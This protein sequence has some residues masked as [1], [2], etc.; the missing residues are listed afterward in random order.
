MYENEFKRIVE[1]SRK[2]SLTFFVGAGVSALS[3]A[4]SWSNLINDICP[5]IGYTPKEPYS[6]DEY[7]RIPQIFYYSIGQNNDMYYDFIQKHLSPFPL[8]PNAVHKELMSFNPSSF[9]TTNFDELLE[10]AAIQYCQSFSI[11]RFPRHRQVFLLFSKP[12]LRNRPR[13]FLFPM[14]LQTAVE[15]PC[16]FYL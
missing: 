9:I 12:A 14:T 7:L 13:L 6:S 11:G 5:Q 3:K 10:D 1:A 15:K 16:Q 8:A 2:N 4:P